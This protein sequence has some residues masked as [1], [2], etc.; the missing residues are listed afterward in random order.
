[1]GRRSRRL[2]R[3]K[4]HCE[5][6]KRPTRE[7]V[8]GRG[9]RGGQRAGILWWA[10]FGGHHW[11]AERCQQSPFTLPDSES[12]SC[13][14]PGDRSLPPGVDS[15][16]DTVSRRGFGAQGA[17]AA[18]DRAAAAVRGTG[19]QL[20]PDAAP[21]GGERIGMGRGMLA[22]YGRYLGEMREEYSLLMD[23]FGAPASKTRELPDA[24]AIPVR[25]SPP[26]P[27][28]LHSRSACA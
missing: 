22:A 3:T 6:S 17:G 24:C 7:W 8:R 14:D 20:S 1:M 2:Q 16:A 25:K 23:S 15:R 5:P 4:V 10:F 12:A 19:H 9:R 28:R 26:F 21:E 11:H 18:A 13:S 27:Y